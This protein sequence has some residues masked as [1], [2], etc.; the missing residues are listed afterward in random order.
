MLWPHATRELVSVPVRV[1]HPLRYEAINSLIT[2]RVFVM[3]R[4]DR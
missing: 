1:R 2:N 3:E 4:D